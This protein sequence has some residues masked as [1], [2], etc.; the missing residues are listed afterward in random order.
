MYHTTTEGQMNL[1]TSAEWPYS[2]WVVLAGTYNA[3]SSDAAPFPVSP[4]FP[5]FPTYS[6]TTAASMDA[7][8]MD[9][10]P[11]TIYHYTLGLQ[12]KLPG[13]AVLDVAYA[14]ARDLHAILGRSINQANLAS[15]G[16]P[17]RGQTT[18]TVANVPLR[19][20]Y[21]GWTPSSMT[22]FRTDGEAWYSALQTSLTQKFRHS[23]QYQ[24]A[25]TWE[26][27]LSP[28]P[29]FTT[30]SNE[31]GP[32]GDQNAL[33]GHGTGYGP[34][35]NVR[36]QRFVLSAYYVLPSP[37]K[38]N[39][40]LANTLG[41]WSLATATVVQSGQEGGITFNNI[42]NVY[43][44]PGDRPSY[45]KGCSAKNVS[46]SGSVS[47]RV[48]KYIN[49]ACL[50]TPAVIGDDGVGTGFG[51]TPNGILREPDQADVDLSLSKNV[52][53]RWP[54][55]GANVQF[56]ADF[57]NAL[58]HPNF[59]GPNNAYGTASFGKI[60]YMSTNPRVM[61]LALRFSF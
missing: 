28:V 11:P 25:Y 44:I 27:L 3:N 33:H 39:A 54:R 16:N 37:A 47:S 17:I 22:Y 30:G 10:R 53:V 55:E 13:G 8:S 58:N 36:P 21:Q 40:L 60:T 59:A 56:R 52:Q 6:P 5:V 4:A 38:S 29:G 46:T 1:Q 26:R 41:G 43:G 18:N 49:A 32:S 57:F 20:P 9:W 19:V 2:G 14:G 12:S 24:A 48:D 51:N 45:A 34:D 61:Q 50:T 42:N 7:L 15:A 35:Y 31:F 23:F